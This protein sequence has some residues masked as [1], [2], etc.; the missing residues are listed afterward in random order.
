MKFQ[1]DCSSIFDDYFKDSNA[2]SEEFD[3]DALLAVGHA[4]HDEPENNAEGLYVQ[5]VIIRDYPGAKKNQKLAEIASSIMNYVPML[6]VSSKILTYDA[7][8]GCFRQ[9]LNSA[10]FIE[11]HICPTVSR[12]LGSKEIAEIEARLCREPSLQADFDDLN[13]NPYLVN[14]RNGVVDFSR[15]ELV[16]LPHSERYKFTYCISANFLE[17]E[18]RFVPESFEKFC[19][20]SL[21]GDS[22]KRLFLLES[23]G[24]FCSDCLDGKCAFFYKGVPNSGKTIVDNLVSDLV[25]IEGVS[26]IQLNHLSARFSAAQLLGKK[27]NC[28]GELRAMKLLDISIFKMLTG[29]DRLMAEDKG[30]KPFF[31]TPRCKHLFSGNV[32]PTVA[33]ADATA[34]FSNR[35]KILLFNN[36]IPPDKQDKK[37]KEK[38]KNES[39]AIFTLAMQA[40]LKLRERNFQFTIPNDSVSFIEQMAKAQNSA[41]MFLKERCIMGP[42]YRIHN[43]DILTAYV[44]YCKQN[45]QNELPRDTLFS[46]ID[47]QPGVVSSRFRLNEEN[48]H[49]RIGIALM[50]TCGTLEQNRANDSATT[51]TGVPAKRNKPENG[52]TNREKK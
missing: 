31:F 28:S 25:G 33:E 47:A 4:I 13:A 8:Q 40:L 7:E 27:L 39:D 45:A 9:V 11:T 2:D 49:G 14:C 42:E 3:D 16:L 41:D 24:Y 34:A 20:T 6:I 29:G 5:N 51:D 35:V 18:D 46:I 30:K 44:E 32:M 15:E 23:I 21:E 48:L 43:R 36:S 19:K 10:V 22:K 1:K 37:L 52:G 26:N 38:L 50:P 12:K 17:D